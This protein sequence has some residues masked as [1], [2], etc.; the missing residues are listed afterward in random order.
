MSITLDAGDP[1][2]RQAV[3]SAAAVWDYLV[4]TA[5]NESQAAAYRSQL[6]V[7]ERLGVLAPVRQALVVADPAGQRVGNWSWWKGLAALESR[8]SLRGPAERS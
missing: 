4:L 2:E 1:N 3:Q 8:P 5:S 6:E 7:R